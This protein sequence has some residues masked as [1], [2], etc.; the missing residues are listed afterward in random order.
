MTREVIFSI[1]L[2]DDPKTFTEA[3]TSRDDPLWKEAINDKMDSI[4]G[5]GTWELANLPLG[6]RPIGYKWIFKK[7]YHLDGSVYAYKANLLLRAI[8]NEKGSI[9]DT[10]ALVARISS[11]RALIEILA[12]KGLYTD[13]MDV[14]TTFLNGYLKEEIYLEK[15]EGFVIPGQENKVFRLIKSLYGLKQAPKQ[16]HE[17]FDITVTAFSFQHNSVDM[18]I[19]F[20]CTSNT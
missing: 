5:N 16:W 8:G 20:T 17:R 15:P 6:R 7:K 3:M 10:Y 18:C 1:N 12:L 9:I 14:K 4:M 13:R 2:D 11:I 19:Y